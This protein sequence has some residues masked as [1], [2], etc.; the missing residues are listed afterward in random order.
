MY[1]TE[2]HMQELFE[3]MDKSVLEYELDFMEEKKT[4]LR[5]LTPMIDDL[6]KAET[7]LKNLNEY[8][9]A[10]YEEMLSPNSVHIISCGL[11]NFIEDIIKTRNKV[12]PW[13][14]M[15]V[16]ATLKVYENGMNNISTS[17]MGFSII[18]SSPLSAAMFS[19]MD[20]YERDK[21]YSK[22][23][24]QLNTFLLDN[25]SSL[26]TNTNCLSKKRVKALL[27]IIDETLETANALI[28]AK[29]HIL[30]N[31]ELYISGDEPEN[32]FVLSILRGYISENEF[33]RHISNLSLDDSFLG[34]HMR[35]QLE[36]SIKVLADENVQMFC[37][38]LS[39]TENSYREQANYRRNHIGNG[40]F[41]V[42]TNKYETKIKNELH[43]KNHTKQKENTHSDIHH[44]QQAEKYLS[45]GLY[46]E[47]AVCFGKCSG[48]KDAYQRSL[49]IWKTKLLHVNFSLLDN[50]ECYALTTN[51]EV[52]TNE[53]YYSD[54]YDE[55]RINENYSSFTLWEDILDYRDGY[56]LTC[57]GEVYG[58]DENISNQIVALDLV[59]FFMRRLDGMLEFIPFNGKDT[60]YINDLTSLSARHDIKKM[61]RIGSSDFRTL[62][63]DGKV[64]KQGKI[65][66][67]TVELRKW[68][69]IIEI[70]DEY[71]LKSDGTV[72][73]TEDFSKKGEQGVSLW[74]NIIH[75]IDCFGCVGVSSDGQVYIAHHKPHGYYNAPMYSAL[76]HTV[77]SWRNLVDV[78]VFPYESN[79]R[80]ESGIGI[81]V[82][83][84]LAN[85]QLVTSNVP[86]DLSGWNN[87]ISFFCATDTIIGI[88]TDGR[89]LVAGKDPCQLKNCIGDWRL[90][91]NINTYVQEKLTMV[92]K[93][94]GNLTEEIA[95]RKDKLMNIRGWF[96]GKKKQKLEEET[97]ELKRKLSVVQYHI[98]A[99]QE[100]IK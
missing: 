46:Y 64:L 76:Y 21:Q 79:F 71:G 48:Y 45:Q 63:A 93:V 88:R 24:N 20:S 65:D 32:E 28:S 70:I 73:T 99:L 13:D 34:D 29:K 23:V 82:I 72:V 66:A 42:T 18:T 56:A 80:S 11:N 51:G 16:Q 4:L 69:N 43:S 37:V 50:K 96:T 91:E 59:P 53:T 61:L 22:Q 39:G 5:I 26:P 97:Q 19:L 2:E 55:T 47:A 15:E 3:K 84:L 7:V 54:Y 33:I 30:E 14:Q 98:N 36:E 44:Y 67:K 52:L 58:K 100:T 57:T 27:E 1:Y 86:Y 25:L 94:H 9:K 74:K 85:G 17:G 38:N 49:D 62:M 12:N 95:T 78:K 8:I 92:Q 31:H 60:E 83:G 75:I 40:V 81:G 68:N 77:E 41:F 87:I 10:V 35:A 90:F 6:Q 89:I